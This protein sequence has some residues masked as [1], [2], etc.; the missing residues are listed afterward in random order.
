MAVTI[1]LNGPSPLTSPPAPIPVPD[2]KLYVVQKTMCDGR[3]VWIS[4][5]QP[6]RL[7]FIV[8]LSSYVYA[9]TISSKL[10]VSEFLALVVDAITNPSILVTYVG[11]K[12]TLDGQWRKTTLGIGGRESRVHFSYHKHKT[13]GPSIRVELNPRKVGKAGFKELIALLKP[14][15]DM[16]GLA[17]AAR[18][19]RL[20][21]AVDVVGVR[22]NEVVGWY[23][24]QGKRSIYLGSDGALETVNIHRKRP[25]HKVKFDGD[26]PQ[27]A[28]HAKQPAGAVV[29]RIY[30]RARERMAISQPPPFGEA[31]VTRIEVVKSR[32]KMVKLADLAQLPDQ[33]AEVRIGYAASQVDTHKSA[34]LRFASVARSLEPDRAV[35]LLAL[36]S[37]QK[38]MLK[39]ALKVPAPDLVEPADAW[40][41]WLIGAQSCGLDLLVGNWEASK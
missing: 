12:F 10:S 7:S 39:K 2:P 17:E 25:P 14:A 34:W 23:K 30:D 6:D 32:F 36:P 27:K 13:V 11:S 33:L 1:N 18:V 16:K 38:K 8:P 31:P 41:G 28:F 22:V 29:V 37:G 15:F 35:Q 21:I 19:T 24:K 40:T 9:D 20:D 26:V 3:M 4:A 5:P